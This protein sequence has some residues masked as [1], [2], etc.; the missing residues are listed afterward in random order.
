MG[1]RMDTAKPRIA[2]YYWVLE[3]TG[4]RND[5]ACIYMN[6]NFRK[7]LNGCKTQEEVKRDMSNQEGNVR[8]LFPHGDTSRFG[9]YDLH[10]LID[11]GEDALGVP[12]D[13]VYPHPNAYWTS[14]THLGY[15]HR[16][17]TAKKFDFVFCAQK[18]AMKDFIRDGVDPSKVFYLPHAAEPDVYRPIPIVERWEWAFIGHLNSIHRVNIL[19]RFIKEWPLG[20]KSY[21]GWREG[22]SLGR[23]VMDDASRKF[24]Q[25]K[26]IVSDSIKDDLNMRTFEALAAKRC[27]LTNNISELDGVFKTNEHLVTYDSIEDAIQKAKILLDNNE[28]RNA[29]ALAGYSEVIAK[30]TYNHRALEILKTCL[31]Y[32]PTKGEK[33]LC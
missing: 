32:T 8:H 18:Q 6:Y 22:D 25:A 24:N 27:L 17:E 19:D 11:H 15:Q 3:S 14:D 13:F 9:Q 5:G 30:H 16:L 12:L 1:Y 10:L 4:N 31:N 7:I 23:N 26:L 28:L 29:I 21:I 33:V 2:L 20:E